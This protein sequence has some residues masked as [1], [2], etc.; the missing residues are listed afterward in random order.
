MQKIETE[1]GEN[2]AGHMAHLFRTACAG[3]H[4]HFPVQSKD[5]QDGQVLTAEATDPAVFLSHAGLGI[6]S[7]RP[8]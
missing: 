7:L 8:L 1:K 4:V 5:Y 6:K 2:G 3:P